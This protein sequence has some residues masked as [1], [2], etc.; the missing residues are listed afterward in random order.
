L[1]AAKK[2]IPTPSNVGA[3]RNYLV[4]N[5]EI[6]YRRYYCFRHTNNNTDT[7][8]VRRINGDESRYAYC[9]AVFVVEP[10]TDGVWFITVTF[11]ISF[12][13]PLSST[14][15]T[16]PSNV[17]VFGRFPDSVF[18]Y[19]RTD[20]FRYSALMTIDQYAESTNTT[21]PVVTGCTR[22]D[23]TVVVR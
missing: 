13:R 8:I 4:D 12:L 17:H 22:L 11:R 15:V 10:Y 14:I 18:S 20:W 1:D 6:Q 2:N 23:N 3:I 5:R 19:L 7:K 21:E 9:V 16:F